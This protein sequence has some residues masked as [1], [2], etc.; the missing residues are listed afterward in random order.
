MMEPNKVRPKPK[1]GTG[2]GG[3]NAGGGFPNPAPNGVPNRWP[4][5]PPTNSFKSD[6]Q[7]TSE[8]IAAN[9]AEVANAFKAATGEPLK[10]L[11]ISDGFR[12][13]TDRAKRWYNEIAGL[14]TRHKPVQ[15]FLSKHGYTQ[16]AKDALT[17]YGDHD[18]DYADAIDKVAS[19]IQQDKDR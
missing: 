1:G 9:A 12:T 16:A 15:E 19:F 2:V 17:V 18:D 4:G 13:P 7:I 5:P 11:T 8:Q 14:R 6:V 10:P 3:A